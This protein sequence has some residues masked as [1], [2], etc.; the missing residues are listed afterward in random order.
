[1]TGTENSQVF[2]ASL[3][4]LHKGLEWP[5]F[6]DSV[7]LVNLTIYSS[8]PMMLSTVKNGVARSAEAMNMGSGLMKSCV[9]GVWL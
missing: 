2:L 9:Y 3:Q 6:P 5:E 1:M 4:V 7:S 8:A